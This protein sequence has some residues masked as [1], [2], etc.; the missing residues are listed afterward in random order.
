M[1]TTMISVPM[2]LASAPLFLYWL[3]RTRLLLRCDAGYI[4]HVL[5]HDLALGRRVLAVFR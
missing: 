5:D 4:A 2:I 3:S 1:R